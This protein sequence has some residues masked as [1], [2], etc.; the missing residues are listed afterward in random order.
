MVVKC[1]EG[2]RNAKFVVHRVDL[3]I[4]ILICVHQAV[5]EVL[6]SVE[7]K[8]RKTSEEIRNR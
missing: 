2:I 6:P 4:E 1:P 3:L 8:P 5:E 7:D